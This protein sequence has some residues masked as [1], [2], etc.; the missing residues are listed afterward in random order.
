MKLIPNQI[1]T[2]QYSGEFCHSTSVIGREESPLNKDNGY[3]IKAI[4]VGTISIEHGNRNIF[5]SESKSDYFMFS[6]YNVENYV[7]D[8]Y[9][10]KEKAELLQRLS[11][12]ETLLSNETSPD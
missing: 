11:E 8:Y 10:Q 4:F 7:L 2:I 1:Y 9:L 3:K 6:A 12:I 5:F